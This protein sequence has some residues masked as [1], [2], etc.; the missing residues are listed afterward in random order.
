MPSPFL[1]AFPDMDP[2]RLLAEGT[3]LG[4][5]W[6]IAHNFFGCR[7]GYIELDSTHPWYLQYASGI[8]ATIHGGITYTGTAANNT[9]K[10]WIGFDTCHS[11]DAADPILLDT[12]LIDTLIPFGLDDGGHI[13]T[14]TEVEAECRNL[15]LQAYDAMLQAPI[16]ETTI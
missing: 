10:Y 2:I 9:S 14:Q 11:G 7:C 15:C 6:A 3:Y 4:F 8:P 13:W 12:D 1:L 16:N 5:N